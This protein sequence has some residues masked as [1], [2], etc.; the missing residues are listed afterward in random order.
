MTLK[1]RLGRSTVWMSAAASG[2]SVVSFLILIV[3]SRILTPAQIGLVAFALIVVDPG[4][5]IVNAG[6]PQAIVQRQLWDNIYASTCFY[7]SMAF[8]LLIASLIFFIGVP[9]VEM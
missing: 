8:A 3:L 5:I 7:L 2:N 1:Q 4:K 9:L 6:F